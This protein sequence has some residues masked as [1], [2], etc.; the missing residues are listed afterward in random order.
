MISE[1]STS[2]RQRAGVHRVLP[3]GLAVSALL[4]AG[5]AGCQDYRERPL[6]VAEVRTEWLGRSPADQSVRA[7]AARLA[8][9]GDTAAAEF[10]P[11]NGLTL[12]E[13]EVVA[14]VFNPDLRVA[15]L[16]LNVM[17][18]TA[19]HAGLW[20]DP[21]FGVDLE[22]IVSGA[23]G[24]D[25]WVVG[26]TVGL[27]I[28]ISGRLDAEK[29]RAGAA[30]AAEFDRLAAREWATRAMLRE[31][32][33]EWSA[34][35]W[36]AES[37]EALSV[38]LREIAELAARQEV[39]GSLSR[40]ES[41]LFA[42]ELATREAEQVVLESKARELEHELRLAMGLSPAA[43]ITLVPVMT[44]P[45]RELAAEEYPA[46]M[47]EFNPELAA[48]RA[49]YEVADRA[50]RAEVRRQYPDLTIGPGY[51]TDQGD[52]RVLLGVSLPIPLWNR[53]QQGVAEAEAQRIVAREIFATTYEHLS[54]RLA[55]ALIQ[56]HAGRLQREAIES[57]VAPMADEQEAEV[58]RIAA[59]GRVEP[60]IML[61][62]IKTQYVAQLQL[63]DARLAES[64]SAI[65]VD[66]LLG[67]APTGSNG[68]SQLDES[69]HSGD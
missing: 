52:D 53:N 9:E 31:R 63:I 38:R 45:V 13:G 12:R 3:L 42:V 14:M 28:P 54:A 19:E 10:D 56:H 66:E 6:S 16:E 26:S 57:S 40:V 20:E 61:E 17:R 62:A 32:W 43:T 68:H 29:Q 41:R 15:R 11:G 22:R 23:G 24:L 1:C 58:R 50:L 49:Q 18:A 36:R 33:M 47:E 5:V 46:Q 48:I 55:I 7:M 35:T 67:P 44:F 51:G 65:R 39:A 37:A 25:P 69:E 21:V 64:I 8:S 27:T 34:A 30:L 60:L 4:S 59:M 2:T